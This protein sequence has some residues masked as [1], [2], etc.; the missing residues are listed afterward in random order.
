VAVAELV[1]FVSGMSTKTIT[2]GMKPT[3]VQQ[4]SYIARSLRNNSDK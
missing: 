4:A 3:A 1:V 2:T